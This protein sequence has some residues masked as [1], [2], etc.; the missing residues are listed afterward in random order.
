MVRKSE[1]LEFISWQGRNFLP[2]HNIPTGPGANLT[3]RS[4]TNVYKTCFIFTCLYGVV[5]KATIIYFTFEFQKYE[6]WN[7]NSGNYLFTTDTK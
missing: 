6:G 4:D 5:L 2:G 1:G 3:S 7:F